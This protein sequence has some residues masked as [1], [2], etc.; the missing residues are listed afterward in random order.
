MHAEISIKIIKKRM[1]TIDVLFFSIIYIPIQLNSNSSFDR[2][3]YYF[4]ASMIHSSKPRLFL[5]HLFSFASHL[6][7][8]YINNHHFL[9]LSDNIFS[10]LHQN[11]VNIYPSLSY[12]IVFSICISPFFSCV[13]FAFLIIIS[14]LSIFTSAFYYI[15]EQTIWKIYCIIYISYISY[16]T[17]VSCISYIS[18]V[19]YIFQKGVKQ[20]YADYYTN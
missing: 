4:T 15:K 10:Y 12:T 8:Q 16:V 11:K 18:Y 9:C 2:N 6:F 20:N 19:R 3:L 5:V 7:S 13:F 1:S 17:Y 14:Q